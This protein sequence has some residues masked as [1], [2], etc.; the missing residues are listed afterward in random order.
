MLGEVW[1]GRC[2]TGIT[3]RAATH[4][5]S[6]GR[7][8]GARGLFFRRFVIAPLLNLALASVAGA[9]LLLPWPQTSSGIACAVGLRIA[10]QHLV[11]RLCTTI[12][13]ISPYSMDTHCRRGLGPKRG[14]SSTHNVAAKWQVHTCG[15][16]DPAA[17]RSRC[18]SA[19]VHELCALLST[20]IWRL[21]RCSCRTECRL[22]AILGRK[23]EDHTGLHSLDRKV[24][25]ALSS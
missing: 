6:R 17:L 18:S 15:R 1:C 13:C 11:H 9:R 21:E 7:G 22:A 5:G 14:Y 12:S 10:A 23:N 25:D 20:H 2:G 8:R 3:G 24:C 16:R 19:V 4:L